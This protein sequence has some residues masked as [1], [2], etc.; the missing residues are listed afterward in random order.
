[1]SKKTLV[2]GIG[3]LLLGDEGVGV[4]AAR[5]LQSE[6]W[7]REVEILEVG[8]AILDALPALEKADRVM[9][10]DA[11]KNDGN[12][13]T[14]YRIP[15]GRCQSSQCIASMHG[16]DIFRVLALTGR[17]VPPDVLVFGVEPSYIGWSMELSPPVT[18]ALAFLLESV[19]KECGMGK[20]EGRMRKGEWGMGN[21]ASGLSEL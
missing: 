4:H 11:M 12:P 1:M 10:L 14:V 2:L 15:L 7:S 21:A 17:E 9:I 13:G 5:A 18:N 3:N 16:F 19:K 8:T 6:E 20:G